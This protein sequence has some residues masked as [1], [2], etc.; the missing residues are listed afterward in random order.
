M[1]SDQL[2]SRRGQ[3]AWRGFAVRDGR[4][5]ERQIRAGAPPC[6]PCCGYVLEAKPTSRLAGQLVLDARGFDLDCRDCRRFWC[7]VVHTPR[8]IRLLRM[9]RLAAAVR[10]AR[11]QP[12]IGVPPEVAVPQQPAAAAL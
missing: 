11:S 8:S 2:R 1:R 9:R 3:R 12:E 6:C 7:L 10:G 5:I 4:E